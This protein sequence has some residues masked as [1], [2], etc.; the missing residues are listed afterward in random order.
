[1]SDKRRIVIRRR[2]P[3]APPEPQQEAEAADAV[4]VERPAQESKEP[5]PPQTAD[6]Y[7]EA[8]KSFNTVQER[9][10][11][12]R[13]LDRSIQRVF[14]K[15]DEVDL[16]SVKKKLN[17]LSDERNTVLVEAQSCENLLNE[18]LGVLETRMSELEEQLFDRL[19]EVEYLRERGSSLSEA[20][21]SRLRALETEVEEYRN[22]IAEI[23]R[24]ISDL[25]L[26]LDN[27][28]SLP[29]TISKLTTSM[30]EAEPLYRE[31]VAKYRD[32][33]RVASAVEKIMQDEGVSR[34]YAIIHLWK[35]A[36]KPRVSGQP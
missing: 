10:R 19:V 26:K 14:K 1:M 9:I 16:R 23:K 28:R 29:R 6:T 4:E 7:E 12:I 2:P 17:Q 27:V 36:L 32:E 30:E 24:K 21:G 15:W 33:A 8:T 34:P 5:P 35:A 18:A 11:E 3:E 25:Q 20:E 13:E 22:R 31:L